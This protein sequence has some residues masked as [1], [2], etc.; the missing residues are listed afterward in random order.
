VDSGLHTIHVLSVAKELNEYI[1]TLDQTNQSEEELALIQTFETTYSDT[2]DA[3]E[4]AAKS[5]SKADTK[6]MLSARKT[7]Q[8]AGDAV[9]K[10][11]AYPNKLL[12]S[13]GKYWYADPYINEVQLDWR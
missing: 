4:T 10:A 7:L 3:F 9:A 11:Q 12:W 1:A 13:T 6:I 2:Q 5:M 8:N